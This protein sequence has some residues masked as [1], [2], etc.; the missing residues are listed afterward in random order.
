MGF[1]RNDVRPSPPVTTLAVVAVAVAILLFGCVVPAT[2]H[3]AGKPAKPEGSEP[4]GAIGSETPDFVWGRAKGASGYELRVLQ[5]GK[6]VLAKTGIKGLTYR[7]KAPLPQNVDLAWQVRARS[8]RGAGPWSDPLGFRIAPDS[9]K[10]ITSFGIRE[11]LMKGLIDEDRHEVYVLLPRGVDLTS[12]VAD[13]TT[14]GAS[15]DIFGDPQVSGLTVNDFALPVRY[16]V[17]ARDGTT[18]DYWVFV[19]T[20]G[21]GDEF[22]GGKVAYLF[23]SADPGYVPGELHGLVAARADQSA[24]TAGTIWSTVGGI[25]GG[26]SAIGPAGPGLA[27]GTGMANTESIVRQTATVDGKYYTCTGGA[28]F[29]CYHLAE[30]GHDDWFL[31]CRA[32]LD[33]LFQ[34]REAIGGF[35]SAGYWSSSDDYSIVLNSATAAWTQDFGTG[36]QA[37]YG[38]FMQ[39]CVRA[40]RQF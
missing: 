31:P 6:V 22:G 39:F 29:I 27:L 13:F 17:T 10:R 11:P 38:K 5:A 21:V 18:Q 20:L 35:S 16:T 25:A 19:T 32:E 26:G 1:Q 3:A 2:T 4:H 37:H 8:S 15:V 14:D 33:K 23:V 34:N 7:S 12:L 9:L 40:V 28:A 36:A 24:G 30:G